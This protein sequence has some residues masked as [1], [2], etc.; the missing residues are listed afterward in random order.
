MKK[1]LIYLLTSLCVVFYTS[2]VDLDLEP[3]DT[4]GSNIF[5]DENSTNL[6][7]N[8]A[9][10]LLPGSGAGYGYYGRN[11]IFMADLSADDADYVMGESVFQERFELDDLNWTTTN[12][13]ITGL[14]GDIYRKITVCNSLTDNVKQEDNP[15]AIGQALFLRSLG[16]FNLVRFYGGVPLITS[17]PV[18]EE[19]LEAS[20]KQPRATINEIYDLIVTDMENVVANNLL[21]DRWPANEN[22]R[23]TL[24]AAKTL[25]ANIY[26]TMAGPG[27]E[28]VGKNEN[29]WLARASQLLRE[30]RDGGVYQ[31][32][33]DYMTLWDPANDYSN[34]EVIF[35]TGNDG[36]LEGG[37]PGRYT[38]N[39]N[40]I[41]R[42]GWQYGWGNN[43][44]SAKVFYSFDDKDKRRNAYITS[45]VVK[46]ERLDA[47]S[48]SDVKTDVGG[49][50]Y[51]ER[52]SVK[53]GETK[54]FYHG[55]VVTY[56]FWLSEAGLSHI[57]RPHLG[58]FSIYGD[59][60][61]PF[62]NVDDNCFKIYRYADVLL[63]LAE[64]EFELKGS[65]PDAVDAINQIRRR[66]YGSDEFAVTAVTR[67]M[68][69][70]ERM[71]ELFQEAKRWF[72]I[73]RWDIFEDVLAEQGKN[74]KPSNR[75]FP[76]PQSE[77]DRN[78]SL[79]QNPGY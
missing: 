28:Y 48:T 37:M 1:Y 36:M 56:E 14:Y 23:A 30:V 27:T 18:T 78:P 61:D 62:A 5:A 7:I 24:G 13:H 35:M 33:P 9:Y 2:C 53:T 77:I 66:A 60:Y 63:M 45:F 75:Y 47:M 11:M 54:Q 46:Q 29:E 67:E 17:E 20:M 59:N 70:D 73:V 38:T 68:I 32:E 58:K 21:P 57:A 72:D 40:P 79:V 34:R 50:K 22:G 19:Q 12:N 16:Y 44:P 49:N 65:S 52:K 39:Y 43:I 71:K 25:L 74:V 26:L 76:I 4:Y 64:A 15:S 55:D 51:L 69:R 6:I 3:L 41:D 10:S 8:Q 31:L 42:V